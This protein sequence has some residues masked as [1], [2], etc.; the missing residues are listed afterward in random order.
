MVLCAF[1][2]IFMHDYKQFCTNILYF[3]EFF[4]ANIE[5]S[6]NFVAGFISI[7]QNSLIYHIRF[8][9]YVRLENRSVSRIIRLRELSDT[10]L[11]IPSLWLPHCLMYRA[12]RITFCSFDKHKSYKRFDNTRNREVKKKKKIQTSIN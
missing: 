1:S 7:F 10:P 12:C 9:M 5:T 6:I 11:F 8:S 2:E 3:L 4:H